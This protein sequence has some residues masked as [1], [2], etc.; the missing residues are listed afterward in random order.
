SFLRLARVSMRGCKNCTSLPPFGQLPS[1]K[2]LSIQHMDSVKVVG[3]EF[4]GNGVSFPSLEV[5]SFEG[6]P[7]WEGW[8]SNGRST[9]GVVRDA[10][11][12]CLKE[13]HIIDWLNS[14]IKEMQFSVEELPSLRVLTIDGCGDGVLRSVVRVAP[15]VTEVEIGSI[16][17]LTNEVWRGVILDL[18]A[19]EELEIRR[20][21][22][23]R[24]LWESKEAETS[25]KVLVNLRKLKVDSCKNLVSLGEKDEEEYNYGS[26]FLT[27][28]SSLEG[29][30]QK[31]KSV[32]IEG[33]EKL[34]LLKEELGE[35]VKNMGLR[36]NSKSMPLLENLKIYHHPN[37]D[38]FGV[39]CPSTDVPTA[40]LWPPNL[41][42][43]LIGRLKNPI[44]EWAH[45]SLPGR[46]GGPW[47]EVPP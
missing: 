13:L 42:S 4:L 20:C 16:S 40:G 6:M 44:S 21:A 23:I 36:I 11:F 45:K 41:C 39:T 33:C 43:L 1:L 37:V 25:S 29:G 31:L 18:K 35:G 30:G 15:S 32:T 2:V 19:V 28:L 14:L 34:L 7:G 8:S 26:N 27:S 24:Y 46:Q 3:S 47:F 22:D 10:V 17:G 5:L 9:T 38:E 12:P